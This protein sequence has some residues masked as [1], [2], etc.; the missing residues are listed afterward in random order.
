MQR[1]PKVAAKFADITVVAELANGTPTT[2][3]GVDVAIV[4]PGT[5]PVASTTWVAANWVAPKAQ[6]LLIGPLATVT[7][8]PPYS[9]NVPAV[10]GDL[11][12]RVTDI[13][14]VDAA[15][16]DHIELE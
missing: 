6:V 5:T 3:T 13:P 4:P 16:V 8:P 7:S 9:L 15:L 10:G 1:L 12:A 2:L 11:W 14:E